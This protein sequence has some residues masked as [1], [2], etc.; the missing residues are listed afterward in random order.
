[1]HTVA[2]GSRGRLGSFWLP[3]WVPSTTTS[4]CN[5]P[6]HTHTHTYTHTPFPHLPPARSVVGYSD[7]T[8]DPQG[9]ARFQR[10][11]AALARS[12]P[13]VQDMSG[14]ACGLKLYDG[15][16]VVDGLAARAWPPGTAPIAVRGRGP[17]CRT[18]SARAAPGL[19]DCRARACAF[20]WCMW[21]RA[22][23]PRAM[24]SGSSCP[25]RS[26]PLLSRGAVAWRKHCWPL[27]LTASPLA[28]FS[29]CCRCGARTR[30]RWQPSP[31]SGGSSLMAPPTASSSRWGATHTRARTH[32][33][34]RART[35]P[36]PH[37]QRHGG[38]RP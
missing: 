36:P 1:M 29:F 22:C 17:W 32:A 25:H 28:A 30:S 10:W 2:T 21:V 9:D 8:G 20:G 18:G 23:G 38:C 3:C 35:P 11:D 7:N 33:R 26:K 37:T 31:P 16:T 12:L 15:P 5:P 13:R 14:I 34:T 6:T 4:A 24:Q 27:P 19:V